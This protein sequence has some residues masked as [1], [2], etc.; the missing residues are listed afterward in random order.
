MVKTRER[1][2]SV[3]QNIRR[4]LIAGLAECHKIALIGGTTY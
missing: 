2:V 1:Q 4:I 3:I